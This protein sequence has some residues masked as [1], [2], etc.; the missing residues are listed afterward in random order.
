MP[1]WRVMSGP[2]MSKGSSA[3]VT[4]APR[5][6]E[7]THPGPFTTPRRPR[8]TPASARPSAT[9]AVSELSRSTQA[10]MSLEQ[11]GPS[12]RT[13]P[14]GTVRVTS[15]TPVNDVEALS[16]ETV[17]NGS[18]KQRAISANS[19]GE[20]QRRERPATCERSSSAL[21]LCMP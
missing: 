7:A 19:V 18:R 8:A 11:S 12:S 17:A 13:P 14:C 16:Q 15:W 1:E 9:S 2:S 4:S 3:S 20:S 21:G 5:V 6:A 10:L